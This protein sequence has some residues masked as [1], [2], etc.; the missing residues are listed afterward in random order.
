[1][2]SCRKLEIQNGL[3]K[4]NHVNL[5][6]KNTKL[7]SFHPVLITFQLIFKNGEIKK[8]P[9]RKFEPATPGF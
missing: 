3:P 7:F 9:P 4:I 1:M 6:K 5:L 2:S 8:K